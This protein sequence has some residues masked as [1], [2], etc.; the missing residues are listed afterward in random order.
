MHLPCRIEVNARI[1]G[2]SEPAPVLEMPLEK[3]IG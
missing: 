1:R 3:L 2:A